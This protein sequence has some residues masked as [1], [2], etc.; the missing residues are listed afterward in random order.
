M[1]FSDY[2]TQ[3][4]PAFPCPAAQAQTNSFSPVT[5]GFP[6][7]PSPASPSFSGAHA[8]FPC[9][10]MPGQVCSRKMKAGSPGSRDPSH[11]SLHAGRT[12][13]WCPH[14]RTTADIMV[15]HCATCSRCSLGHVSLSHTDNDRSQDFYRG[16]W[17]P[18]LLLFEL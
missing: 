4:C 15:S 5:P 18:H 2:V 17:H 7:R 11:E 12:P 8:F 1:V 3:I 13:V 14:G 16:G 6:C 9:Q 10:G